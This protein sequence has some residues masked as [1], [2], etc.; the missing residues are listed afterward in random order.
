MQATVS[1]LP[2]E[3]EL[4]QVDKYEFSL[5]YP[6]HPYGPVMVDEPPPIGGDRGP[7]PTQALAAAVGHCLS[8]TLYNSLARA[9]VPAKPLRTTVRAEVGRNA[10][11][12]L[13]VLRLEVAIET[14]PLH[15]EDRERFDH[16]VAIFEDYCTVSGAIREGIRIE[17][18]VRPP[19]TPPVSG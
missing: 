8:S 14:E 12:R 9:H 6:G 10:K 16:A 11:G 15:E 1:P 3:A 18:G 5:H 4:E 19:A 13:R 7:S 2:L 17:S